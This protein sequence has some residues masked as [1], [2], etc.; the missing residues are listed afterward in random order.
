MK[1]SRSLLFLFALVG[2]VSAPVASAQVVA[3]LQAQ[4]DLKLKLTANTQPQRAY[5]LKNTAIESSAKFTSFTVTQKDWLIALIDD[6]AIASPLKGWS[7][8]ARSDSTDAFVLN[9]RLFA[10]KVGQPDY[11]LDTEENRSLDLEPGFTI[12]NYKEREFAGGIFTGSGTL[13]GSVLGTFTDAGGTYYLGG[14]NELPYVYKTT[15]MNQIK[16][17]VP[18]PGTITCKVTGGAARANLD[19]SLYQTVAEGVISLKSHTVTKLTVVA[20]Q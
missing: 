16:V 18:V 19:G 11:P 13:K 5:V 12:A 17:N 8:I 2:A 7:I 14:L 15:I 4:F 20:A 9:Y 6:G 1:S 10:V 3:D